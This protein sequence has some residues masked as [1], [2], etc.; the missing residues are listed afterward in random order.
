MRLLYL[1]CFSGISGDMFLGALLDLGASQKNLERELHKLKLEGWH[2]H[3]A[4]A[5]NKNVAGVRLEVHLGAHTHTRKARRAHIFT[6]LHAHRHEHAHDHRAYSDIRALI[7]RAALSPFVKKHALNI[8]R[9]VAEAEAKIHGM[10]PDKVHFHEVGAIDSIVDIVGGCIALEELAVD[11]VQASELRT[12]FGFV[13]CAHG[14][15]PVPAMATLE[16]LKGIPHSQGDEPFELVT[17]TGAAIVAEFARSFGTMPTL[18]V[19]KI[20][21]GLGMRELN[22]T[23]NVL[24]AVLGQ[25]SKT[26]TKAKTM[27][28]GQTDYVTVIETNLDNLNPE[29]LGAAMEDLLGQGAL[30]VFFTPI[31]MKKN[32]PAV[33]LSVICERAETERFARWLLENTT[34]FGVRMR[35]ERR[36]KLEREWREEKTRFGKITVKI[37]RLDGKIVTVSPEFESCRAAAGAKKAPLK[38]VYAEAQRVA[39]EIYGH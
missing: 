24:R 2:L 23:P 6:N 5:L 36:L 32:R 10:K 21:Y 29:L 19:E 26:T 13:D 18:R 7:E 16:L 37:G 39:Q 25:M 3:V 35:E 30:D 14:R 9:R 4:R 33:R 17:P 8:F 31:Q 38:I 27:A 22:K 1:D 15:F 20:G 34:T 12:G 28:S 11:A